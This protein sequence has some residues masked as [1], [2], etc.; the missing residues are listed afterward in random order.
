VLKVA[1][2]AKESA[3]ILLYR[4]V[5]GGIEVLLAHP[6][7]P[8][9]AKKDIGVWSIPKG[10]YLED[11]DPLAAA[12]R[13]FAEEIG[14]PV[15]GPFLELQPRKQRSGK[16]VRAWAAEGDLDVATVA[17]NLFAME[18]PPRSGKMQSF[19]EVDRAE[20]FGVEEARKRLNPGQVPILDELVGML[21]GE[22]ADSIG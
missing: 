10:E 3:G 12:R 18:W 15:E 13:E 7:G 17:S 9:W 21:G 20:W 19:P 16:I 6:G 11:E 5:L 2:M 1:I 8:F 22:S 14:T 4:R